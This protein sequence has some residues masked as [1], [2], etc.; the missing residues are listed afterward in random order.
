[1]TNFTVKLGDRFTL[2]DHLL[3]C[4]DCTDA[5]L[6][7]DVLGKKRISLILTDP[8][9]GIAYVEGKE[10]FRKAKT[11]HAAIKNDHL[12]SDG[13]YRIFTRRWIETAKPFLQRKN[14]LYVFNS[15]RMIFPLRDGMQDAGCHLAQLLVW[16]KTQAI[17]GRLDYLPQHELI[18][19][20]WLGVHEFHKSKD[21]SVI[22]YPK[23]S[24]SV[25]HPTMKPVGLLRQLILNSSK[26]GDTVYEPF[27]GS[28]ST[29][30]ACEQTRRKCIAVEMDPH[31]CEVIIR[32]FEKLA[33]I[34][35]L[36]LPSPKTHA[37]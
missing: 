10:D 11:T 34:D 21:K 18:A 28:G 30:I 26:I 33:G 4:G 35:A 7:S 1:M 20:G 3:V 24:K 27:A 8:P 36:K 14:A 32:R 15:D 13:E 2:G 19:Y 5:S 12:Q 37:R 9:Y 16:V 29:L 23:P 31:Y 6:A 17:V 22:V 25:L